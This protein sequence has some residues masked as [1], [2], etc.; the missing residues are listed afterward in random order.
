MSV[1]PISRVSGLTFV[2]PVQRIV[3]GRRGVQQPTE[4][5]AT[6]TDETTTE[7]AKFR[8]SPNAST[9]IDNAKTDSTISGSGQVEARN[10]RLPRPKKV[11]KKLFGTKKKLGLSSTSSQHFNTNERSQGYEESMRTWLNSQQ[12]TPLPEQPF[13]P[14]LNPELLAYL[15]DKILSPLP[16]DFT[17]GLVYCY[18]MHKMAKR[19]SYGKKRGG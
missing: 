18:Q 9:A 16:G 12:N 14:L 1:P 13:N 17:T 3:A 6:L 5:A 7:R 10:K 4:A 11:L 19:L 2:R 15:G 8:P